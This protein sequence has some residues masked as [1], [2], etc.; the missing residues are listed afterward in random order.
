MIDSPGP[1]LDVSVVARRSTLPAELT[2]ASVISARTPS[3][4]LLTA[5]AA[6]TAPAPPLSSPPLSPSDKPPASAS[7]L[8]LSVASS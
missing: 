4:M 3:F 8:A 5:T 6:P 7:M 2:V 1:P